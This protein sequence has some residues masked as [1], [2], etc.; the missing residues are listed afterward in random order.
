MKLSKDQ[1]LI[2][3]LIVSGIKSEDLS[4]GSKCQTNDGIEGN[5]VVIDSCNILRDKLRNGTIRT[6]QV[7]VCNNQMR[8]VCCPVDSSFLSSRL[9]LALCK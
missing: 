7:T 9:N 2:F 6:S 4:S 3:I 1:L 5:C 8:Y